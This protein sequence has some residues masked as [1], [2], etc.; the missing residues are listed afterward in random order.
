MVIVA[1]LMALS[2]LSFI[3]NPARFWMVSLFGL[4]FLPLL[5]VNVVLLVWAAVRRS[6][7]FVIPLV[8]ILPCVF[9]IGRYFQISTEEDLKE[10][11]EDIKVITYNVGRFSMSGRKAGVENNSQCADSIFSYLRRQDADI[12]C[13]QEFYVNN[14]DALEL[15]RYIRKQFPDHRSE[16]YMFPGKNGSFGNITLSKL[17]VIG[18]GVVKFEE[19]AN[20]AIFTDHKVGERR[21]RVYNCHFESYNVSFTGMVRSLFRKGGDAF[22]QTGMKIRKSIARRPKQV[23]KVFSHI[24][25]CPY[26]SF[27]CGDFNDNPMSYSYH[28][29]IRGRGDAFVKAGS[30]LGATYR[31]FWPM[32]RIDY[33]LSPDRFKTISCEVD[34]L[35]FS[36]HYPVVA[37]IMF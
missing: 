10:D 15:K 8:A 14:I 33:I 26:E 7:A 28:R 2:Y 21:F 6:K 13:L 19:S 23:D 37:G 5:A 30:G 31:H 4:A 16:Y 29:L 12:I 17:P 18:K 3:I 32:L 24:E 22:S 11:V 36:D 25:Q 9:F 20:L 1:V 34:R 35:G 27:V